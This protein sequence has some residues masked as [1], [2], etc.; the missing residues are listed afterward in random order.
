[1]ASAI[2]T[3]EVPRAVARAGGDGAR[4]RDVLDRVALAAVTPL[5]LDAAA[6]LAPSTM[7]ALD[8][9]HLATALRIGPRLSALVTYD[10]RLATAARAHG[11]VVS[12]PKARRA[13]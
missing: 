12:A 4:V 8:A 1:V 11:V 13:R 3:V 9:I 6:S 7:R 10:E 5:V 2:A